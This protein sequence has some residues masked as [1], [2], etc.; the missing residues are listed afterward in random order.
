[1]LW[2]F[3]SHS[4]FLTR[5]DNWPTN[6]E[7]NISRIL[8]RIPM[9]DEFLQQL[10]SSKTYYILQKVT[11]INLFSGTIDKQITQPFIDQVLQSRLC[12][13]EQWHAG[14][15]VRKSR[16]MNRAKSVSNFLI[17]GTNIIV[18]HYGKRI[19]ILHTGVLLRADLTGH[20]QFSQSADFC[21]K[22]WDG[23]ALLGQPSKGCQ[24]RISTL[25]PYSCNNI[26]TTLIQISSLFYFGFFSKT[27]H[28]MI[29]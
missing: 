2:E 16:N 24:C 1:M 8:F 10:T 17:C 25:F 11:L 14:H 27:N 9:W 4:I 12:R 23:C 6:F 18:E 19:E 15:T 29:I 5:K 28:Q 3:C 22:G 13:S 7:K 26:T 21:Q 20:G